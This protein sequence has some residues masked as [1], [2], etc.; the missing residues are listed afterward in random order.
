MYDEYDGVYDLYV[1]S[2]WGPPAEPEAC[3]IVS[4]HV[5]S[6]R[7]YEEFHFE[8]H[9][10]PKRLKEYVREVTLCLLKRRFGQHW[11][12]AS[13]KIKSGDTQDHWRVCYKDPESTTSVTPSSQLSPL[14]LSTL[15]SMWDPFPDY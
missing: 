12:G 3:I 11:S 8:R 1:R 15:V 6:G 2:Y 14:P 9:V 7:I 5:E 4:L 13:F 10:T